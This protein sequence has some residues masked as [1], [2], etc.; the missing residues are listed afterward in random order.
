MFGYIS[1]NLV[2]TKSDQCLNGTYIINHPQIN[3]QDV[4]C[5]FLY[6]NINVRKNVKDRSIYASIWNENENIVSVDAQNCTV[7]NELWVCSNPIIKPEDSI[8]GIEISAVLDNIP[9]KETKF[10]CFYNEPSCDFKIGP[11]E[12]E[13][14]ECQMS[15]CST[16]YFETKTFNIWPHLMYAQLGIL[17][18]FAVFLFCFSKWQSKKYKNLKQNFTKPLPYKFNVSYSLGKRNILRNIQG[19]LE[20]GKLTAMMGPSGAGKS[21]LLDVLAQV[22]MSGKVKGSFVYGSKGVKIGCLRFR[23]SIGYVIQND[24]FL[25]QLTVL[26]TLWFAVNTR[27]PET[28]HFKEKEQ[29]INNVLHDLNLWTIRNSR[30]GNL[31]QRSLSG[32]EVRRLSIAVEIISGPNLLFMDEPTSGLDAN[33]AF[34]MIQNL[35]NLCK[36]LNKTILCTIHQP[37]PEVFDLFDTILLLS[38]GE[39]V[40]NG[41]AKQMKE[42]FESC[43]FVSKK[44]IADFAIDVAIGKHIQITTEIQTQIQNQE[45]VT[46]N[47]Q[48]RY[49]VSFW[50]QGWLLVKRNFCC[51][52]RDPKTLFGHLIFAILSSLLIGLFFFDSKLDVAGIQNK[53]SVC[54]FVQ[55]FISL[56]SLSVITNL[57]NDIEVFKLERSNGRYRPSLYILAKIF[58]DL[59]PLR[60][61][62]TV[63][64]A[65]IVYIMVGFQ[66]I[67]M[68]ILSYIMALSLFCVACFFTSLSIGLLISDTGIACLVSTIVSIFLLSFN[69]TFMNYKTLLPVVHSLQYISPFKYCTEAILAAEFSGLTFDAKLL[70]LDGKSFLREYFSLDVNALHYDL[71]CL[72]WINSALFI[73]CILAVVYKVR[74]TR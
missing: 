47:I 32:G 20:P 24:L 48:P 31:K 52:I 34:L 57:V 56:S 19:V 69:G 38:N 36:N 11:M 58:C 60:L 35:S 40:Y 23:N 30:V 63:F 49:F 62:P 67:F 54:V 16:Q 51:L 6:G 21:T 39:T 15:E 22:E 37:R 26:E 10:E 7:E 17:G 55:L 45:V 46:V 73:T 72:I 13:K 59:I 4:F 65:L 41:P 61:I 27:L 29:L 66:N 50:T 5:K 71:L 74:D 2:H 42:Y 1:S 28:M 3:Q 33:N 14:I 8:M 43:G 12:F 25:P 18:F 44:H 9:D 64:C 68:N 53:V 70:E